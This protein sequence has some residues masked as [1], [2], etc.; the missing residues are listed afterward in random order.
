MSSSE[1]ELSNVEET[2]GNELSNNE[3]SGNEASEDESSEDGNNQETSGQ[4]DEDGQSSG[5][6]ESAESEFIPGPVRFKHKRQRRRSL[7]DKVSGAQMKSFPEGLN[8]S[9]RRNEWI[10]WREQLTLILSLKR[11]LKSQEEKLAFLIV[12]GGR[13]I[14]KALKNKEAP[15]EITNTKTIPVFDNALKRL[16][17]YFN[18]G[19]NAITDIIAFRN[20]L[21]RQGEQFVDFVHRLQ[22]QASYCGFGQAE[23]NEVMMQIRQGA[24][25]AEKLSEMMTR[26][27]KTLAN[28]IN[29]GSSLDTEESLVDEKPK[30]REVPMKSEEEETVSFVQKPYNKRRDESARYQ[31]YQDNCRGRSRQQQRGRDT[32][33]P[34]TSYNRDGRQEVCFNCNRPG[35]YARECRAR[36][37]PRN[38]VAYASEGEKKNVGQWFD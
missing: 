9:R 30:P 14:Q 13:E 15:G 17:Y 24:K 38:N 26:E 25:H 35:H 16:D 28:V 19:T 5:S 7:K 36:R 18:T 4:E 29:Y 21:Q 33:R 3:S 12:S 22:E 37:M 1:S 34:R 8:P 32:Q 23:D 31:P 2:S 10:M 11:S 20:I 6:S 27:N